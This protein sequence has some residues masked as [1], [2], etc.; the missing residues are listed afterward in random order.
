MLLRHWLS[1]TDLSPPEMILAPWLPVGGIVLLHG[2]RGVSK[3]NVCM[4]IALAVANGDPFLDFACPSPRKVLYIDGEMQRALV[5][6]RLRKF[7]RHTAR[8]VAQL[9]L[10]YVN[11]ADYNEEGFGDLSERGGGQAVIDELIFE[12]RS[13]AEDVPLLLILDNK[14]TLLTTSDDN[15]PTRELMSFLRWLLKLRK[16]NVTTILVHHTGKAKDDKGKGAQ[17]GS[18]ALERFPDVIAQLSP[19][20][21]PVDG[22]IPV[23][24]TYEKERS[25]TPT[26]REFAF[27]IR[28]D[29]VAGLAWLEMG[30]MLP[31]PEERTQHLE[32]FWQQQTRHYLTVQPKITIDNLAK[33]TNVSRSKVGRFVKT[34]RQKVAEG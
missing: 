28:Y 2:A 8:P 26:E 6:D 18:S 34:V 9:N 10:N 5:Q 4:G 31:D 32:P 15:Q 7:V 23:I 25:F 13:G 17:H 11:Y 19:N 3:T 14:G 27:N 29:D 30:E 1:R 24:W 22:N 33:I 16:R 21:V 20:G 12:Q